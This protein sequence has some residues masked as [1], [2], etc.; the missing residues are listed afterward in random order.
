[1]QKIEDDRVWASV[2][3]T[4]NLGNYENIKIEMGQSRT[5]RPGEDPDKLAND[6]CD[7]LINIIIFYGQEFNVGYGKGF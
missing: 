7:S 2:S 1:M 6:L 5:V 3:G 4:V